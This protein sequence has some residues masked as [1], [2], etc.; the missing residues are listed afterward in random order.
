VLLQVPGVDR[1]AGS[2]L[3][4]VGSYSKG[5]LMQMFFMEWDPDMPAVAA[6]ARLS[7]LLRD[8]FTGAERSFAIAAAVVEAAMPVPNFASDGDVPQRIHT[9]R[10][11]RPP[12]G[13]GP[14]TSN[15]SGPQSSVA[16]QH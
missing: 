9:L 4:G 2:R 15:L 8:I 16:A 13:K 7:N 1:D 10:L 11:R 14:A 3:H 5:A 12:A 6:N